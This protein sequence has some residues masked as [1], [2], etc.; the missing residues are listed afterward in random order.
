M[1]LITDNNNIYERVGCWY[2]YLH[3]KKK[4]KPKK[5]HIVLRE[6]ARE[7]NKYNLK[8]NHQQFS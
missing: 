3:K 4:T 5:A 6:L 8:E 2:K 1:L 7:R